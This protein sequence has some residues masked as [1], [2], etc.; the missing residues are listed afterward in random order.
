MTLKSA[1]LG[2]TL[3]CASASSLVNAQSSEQIKEFV[4]EQAQG[5]TQSTCH[6][7]RCPGKEDI[8]DP[9]LFSL[10]R[11][12][13]EYKYKLE[14]ERLEEEESARSLLRFKAKLE[15]EER[16]RPLFEYKNKLHTFEGPKLEDIAK[17]FAEELE[18]SGALR[19]KQRVDIKELLRSHVVL[20]VLPELYIEENPLHDLYQDGEGNSIDTEK[21]DS[22]K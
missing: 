9:S 4:L 5:V 22:L 21:T 14:K 12:R 15:Q 1:L 18:A 10:M 20:P 13:E 19:D 6:H 8:R 3:F 2:A 11:E 7:P 16:V 17:L